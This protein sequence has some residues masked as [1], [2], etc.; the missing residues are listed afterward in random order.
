MRRAAIFLLFIGVL[1][2]ALFSV[3]SPSAQGASSK[4]AAPLAVANGNAVSLSWRLP[5]SP[6]PLNV[7]IYR[8]EVGGPLSRIGQVEAERRSFTDSNVSAALHASRSLP[9]ASSIHFTKT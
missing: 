6:R 7:V 2:L 5:V 9:D 8:G 4:P 1:A 3:S